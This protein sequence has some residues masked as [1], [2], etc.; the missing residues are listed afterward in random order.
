[1][2]D[3]PLPI[4]G[5]IDPLTRG[6]R[7]RHLQVYSV[8][9]EEQDALLDLGA[10]GQVELPSNP[11]YVVWQDATAARAGFFAEK[12][13][14]HRVSLTADGS[15][16]V[17]TEVILENHATDGPPSPLLGEGATGD[18]IGYFAA[19][20]NV[21]LPQGATDVESSVEPG[22]PL[23][24]VEQE[25]GHPVATELL[26]APPGE[27]ARMA[28][29]YEVPGAVVRRGDVWE[30]RL[31]YL[32]Q[33]ALTPAGLEVEIALPPGAEVVATS[34]GLTPAGPGVRFEGAP[35]ARTGIWVRFRPPS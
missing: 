5:L 18:P 24:I 29:T 12:E 20:V 26:G 15:A 33:P 7:E 34:P 35:A 11:L 22:V 4:G 31:G 1:V 32:P 28:V 30:Y 21:Y 25:F 3:N 13:T 10:G 19:F 9:L 8:D 2:L 23:G 17:E 27:Q 6:V 14:V 16:T